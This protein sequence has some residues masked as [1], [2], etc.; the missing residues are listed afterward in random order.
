MD[1][2]VAACST[3]SSGTMAKLITDT[4]IAPNPARYDTIERVQYAWVRAVISMREHNAI[5]EDAPWQEAWNAWAAW[6]NAQAGAR[7]G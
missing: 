4:R 2:L 3:I 7:Q 6:F 5:S 1:K